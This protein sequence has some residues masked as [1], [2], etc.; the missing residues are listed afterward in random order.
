MP[1]IKSV[2]SPVF[3]DTKVATYFHHKKQTAVTSSHEMQCL[4]CRLY[5]MTP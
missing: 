4:H 5:D 2:I 3:S 1:K